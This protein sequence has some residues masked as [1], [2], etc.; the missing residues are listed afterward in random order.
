M[1]RFVN[2][3]LFS[4]LLFSALELISRLVLYYTRIEV[5]QDYAIQSPESGYHPFNNG[6]GARGNWP[7]DRKLSIALFGSSIAEQRALKHEDTWPY[8]LEKKFNSRIRIDNFSAGSLKSAAI[9]DIA[10]DLIRRG[11]RYDVVFLN[12]TMFYG[13]TF[14]PIHRIYDG[15]YYRR[16]IVPKSHVCHFCFFAAE[17]LCRWFA[18]SGGNETA[19][20]SPVRQICK[21]PSPAQVNEDTDLIVYSALRR[22]RLRHE[23]RLVFFDREL[24]NL[25]IQ[26]INQHNHRL[27]AKLRE[28]SNRVIWIPELIYY[29]PQMRQSYTESFITLF[30]LHRM[31]PEAE[32]G[33]FLDEKSIYLRSL[34]YYEVMQQTMEDLTVPEI[35]WHDQ[36]TSLLTKADGYNTDEYHLTA[37]GALAFADIIYP[38]V[39]R[40]LAPL[41]DQMQNQKVK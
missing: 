14:Y 20:L 28:L 24:S 8:L 9:Q 11:I 31:Q 25:E 5:Q 37:K 19:L 26:T 39:A 1:A 13:D 29:T 4:V 3:L 6:R 33:Y 27:I 2:F 34:R 38:Q 12:I 32:R 17:N 36:Y 16:F 40:E 41:L 23:N 15:S 10:D 30:P 35:H 22:N 7:D 21:P 18:V